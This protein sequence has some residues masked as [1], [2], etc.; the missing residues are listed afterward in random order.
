MSKPYSR[1][2]NTVLLLVPWQPPSF[3]PHGSG[4]HWCTYCALPFRLCCLCASDCSG[5]PQEIFKPSV[6]IFC[7]SVRL[8]WATCTALFP[9][10]R[11]TMK[12]LQ[13]L[14]LCGC[15]S[16]SIVVIHVT[17]RCSVNC[18]QCLSSHLHKEPPLCCAGCI[19]RS[20]PVLLNHPSSVSMETRHVV[21]LFRRLAPGFQPPVL[22]FYPNLYM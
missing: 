5:R 2:L 3:C 22:G 16:K 15:S 10:D 9:L 12:L 1:L 21:G 14:C 4:L 20:C 11:P 6:F 18:T 8:L 7:R 17:C 13:L 19:C